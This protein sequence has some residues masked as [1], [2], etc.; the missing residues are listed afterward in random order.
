[1]SIKCIAVPPSKKPS[2]LASFGS[3]TCTI[4]VADSEG[5]FPGGAPV[6]PRPS[7]V[8]SNPEAELHFPEHRRSARRRKQEIFPVLVEQRLPGEI[9]VHREAEHEALEADAVRRAAVDQPEARDGLRGP[10]DRRHVA[11]DVLLEADRRGE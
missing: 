5:R 7:E 9:E 10:E 1:M 6:M 8:V 11:E 4:S 2:G 3:T